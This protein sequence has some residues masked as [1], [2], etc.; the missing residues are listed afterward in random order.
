MKVEFLLCLPKVPRSRQNCISGQ[1]WLTYL[2]PNSAYFKQMTKA[3]WECFPLCRIVW[4]FPSRHSIRKEFFSQKWS[5]SGICFVS[6]DRLPDPVWLKRTAVPLHKFLFSVTHTR[7]SNQT[8]FETDG[9]LQRNRRKIS[10]DR[11]M[12][13]HFSL[14]SCTGRSR[15]NGKCPSPTK[16]C[17]N[18]C[19]TTYPL[20]Q[21][22]F[23][24]LYSSF[25][26]S[27]YFLLLLSLILLFCQLYY[28]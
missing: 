28:L 3:Y 2:A 9:I 25:L 17:E 10:L 27:I 21:F 18:F 8:L 6:F 19:S 1:L 16:Y 12:S 5:I 26:N 23:S 11:V 14:V 4:K 7:R 24:L 15:T 22:Y 13:F 20:R